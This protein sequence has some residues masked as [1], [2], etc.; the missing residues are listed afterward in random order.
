VAKLDP[1]IRAHKEWLG[2]LQPVGLVVSPPALVKAQAIP[3][4]NVIELQQRLLSV[5][6]DPPESAWGGEIEP[7]ISDPV[8]FLQMVLDWSVDDIAGAPEGPPIP[9][10]LELVLPDYNE[11]LRATFVGI[12]SMGDGQPLLLFKMLPRGTEFDDGLDDDRTGWSASPQAKLERLLRETKVPAGL[13]CNGDAFR[14]V[15]APSGESSGHLTFP[16]A[17]MCEVSGR[18][19][20]AALHMLLSE[21]RVFSAPDGRRLLDVLS[22]SR[23]YQ[24]EVSNRLSDQVLGAL[25]ELLR[26]FQASDPEDGHRV[27][28]QTAREDP[29]HVYGGLLTLLMRLIF[30]L[31]AEDEELMP[32]GGIY[33][34]NYAVSGLYDRLRSDAG[35]YPDTMDQRYGGYAS[36]V[37]LFRLVFDGGGHGELRLPTRHGQLFNPDEFSFLEGRSRGVGRVMD[38]KFEPPRLSDGC[39]YRVLDSLLV[40]DGERLSYRALDVEQVGSVYE[41]MMGYEV[42]RA[43]GRSIALRPNHIV[44][45]VDELLRVDGAKRKKWIKDRA[46]SDLTGAALKGLKEATS[47]EDI[48]A[49]LGRRVSPRS[50]DGAGT[51]RLMAPGTLYLQPGE[52]RRRT[53]S[54]YTPRELTEPIVRTTLR[55]VLQALGERPTPEQI[56][57]LKV[58]DPAMGSGA[59]LVETCRQ[60]SECLVNAW[61]IHDAMP[62]IPADEEPVLHARRLVAQRCL[63]GVDKNPFAV[64]LAKLSIWLVTLAKDH[65]F[66]F[67]DHAFRAGDSLVGLTMQ[68]IA[69][70]HWNADKGST[71]DAFE[72]QLKEDLADV[73]GWR[74][75]LHGIG[76]GDYSQKMEAWWEAENALAD[77]RLLGD[78]V[79]A[80]FF[81]AEKSKDREEMRGRSRTEVEAWLANTD[82]RHL[83]AHRVQELRN[84]EKAIS[85]LHWELEFPEVFGRANPGFDAVVGNPPFAGKNTLTNATRPGYID[86]LKA[87]HLGAHGNA[88]LVTH[89]FRR[90]FA[91]LRERGAF[92]LIATNTVRRGH[93]RTSGLGYICANGGTIFVANRRMMWPGLAAVVISRI[94]VLKGEWSESCMLDGKKCARITSFLFDRGGNEDPWSLE[95]SLGIGFQGSIP[96]GMGFTFDDSDKKGIASSIADM[97][98]LIG[99]DLQNAE[100]ILP[101]IG[102]AEVANEPTH[103]HHRYVINFGDMTLDQ[104]AR[105]PD[106]LQIVEQ[107]V[108]PDRESNRRNAIARKRAKYW[109]QFGSPAKEL[110][111]AISGSDRVLVTGAQAAAQYAFTFLPSGPV[112][113][114]NLNVFPFSEYAAFSVFQ[115]RVHE[116]WARF[117]G[118]TRKDDFS[119]TPTT[120][121]E[122]FAFPTAWKAAPALA[123]AGRAYF[124]YR[125]DLMIQ[126]GKGLTKTYNL[127]HD[128]EV[129][130]GEIIKLRD[131]HAAMDRAVLEAYGWGDISTDCEF[132]LDYQ[133]D[134]AAWEGKRKPYK[135]RWPEAVHDEVLSRL[136]E[137]NQK[138]HNDE[139]AAGLHA[140]EGKKRPSSRRRSTSKSPPTSTDEALSL[141]GSSINPTEDT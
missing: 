87:L 114:S 33:A 138:R 98:R 82:D 2:L 16:V 121:L 61:E 51:P 30:V 18:P 32:T 131:L 89:F 59:F 84:G 19:I 90:S 56:L 105:W 53:G 128:P 15:Y 141:F 85:P 136:L 92:G 100:R 116:V 50:L 108:K 17:A 25:W 64:N 113:S 140:E 133:I 7:T 86:W 106:L 122:T 62:S 70:F 42:E 91:L 40:L 14:L 79:I 39:I 127:F 139:V 11:T 36:L 58:C 20:L 111:A 102:Y 10:G 80:A 132:L 66:T 23:K 12:D 35:R 135:Y 130:D 94:F 8:A 69:A 54:H 45:S 129:L 3:S 118:S 137:L 120:C 99:K 81:G 60:L 13:L 1:E 83:L 95:G 63:Y 96:L 4:Q 76:E 43:S 97:H 134:D 123:D 27:F 57:E 65:A 93:S 124:S 72:Q 103:A 24:A 28:D 74:D 77:A 31:Y 52:E 34:N 117:F 38:E 119:Y 104:A 125:A 6:E 46:D 47:G 21:H 26:G 126:S 107:R 68:Q 48:V 55:P 41:A 73:L 44:V 109:W 75:A 78:L 5:V 115:C 88:D 29:E 9:D 67:V 22:E 49:A 110:Y 101:F 37:S 112:F 71:L